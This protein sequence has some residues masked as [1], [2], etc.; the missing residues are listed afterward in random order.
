[1]GSPLPPLGPSDAPAIRT[2][3]PI[4]P[5]GVAV[6]SVN[7]LVTDQRDYLV[8]KEGRSNSLA[9]IGSGGPDTEAPQPLPAVRVADRYRAVYVR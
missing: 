8:Y 4:I 9:Q 6:L 1:M 2:P 7:G 3:G 5:L